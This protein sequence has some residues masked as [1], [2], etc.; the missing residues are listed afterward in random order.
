MDLG[1]SFDYQ[2]AYTFQVRAIDGTASVTLS[3]AVVEYI[4]Q[5]GTPVFDWGENDFKFNVP[6]D[7]PGLTINGVSLATYIMNIVNGS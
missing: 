7:L 1:D 4:V 3:T 5:K 6:V 2:K